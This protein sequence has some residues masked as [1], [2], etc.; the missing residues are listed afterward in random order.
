MQEIKVDSDVFARLQ[1]LATPFLDTPND[2]LRRVLGID[3]AEKGVNPPLAHDDPWTG[4]HHGA[5]DSTD[6]I[7][8][9]E[10]RPHIL[11]ILRHAGGAQH[12]SL[13]LD[14]LERRMKSRS[15]D[16]DYRILSKDEVKWRNAARWE[17]AVMVRDGL[18]KRD[19]R[20]GIW[21]LTEH[22][23]STN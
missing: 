18:I 2:V 3:L 12:V 13:V 10:Y 5:V 6:A 21:E 7:P 8:R 11:D 15:T 1:A 16:A 20:R 19:S 9:K 17:R 22:G 4:D 23:R 14:E